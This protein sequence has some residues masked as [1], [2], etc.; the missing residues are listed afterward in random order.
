[1]QGAGGTDS[2]TEPTSG[3]IIGVSNK[4]DALASDARPAGRFCFDGHRY[5]GYG[6]N[7]KLS[8]SDPKAQSGVAGNEDHLSNVAMDTDAFF[9]LDCLVGT[10]S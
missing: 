6:V 10:C 5:R 9:S 8:M 1:M 3:T 7:I 4:S 2:S